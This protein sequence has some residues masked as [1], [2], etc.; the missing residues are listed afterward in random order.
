[1]VRLSSSTWPHSAQWPCSTQSTETWPTKKVSMTHVACLNH[2]QTQLINLA[3]LCPVAMLISKYRYLAN[4][5]SQHDT[6]SLFEPWSDSPHP[7]GH[8]LPSGHAHLKVQQP[9]D[10]KSQHDTCHQFGPWSHSAHQHSAT[11]CQVTML[12]S[13]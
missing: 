12:I 1:M 9:A 13:K 5:K 2:G 7:L 4:Q 6:R 10:Q 11:F 3:T 8:I